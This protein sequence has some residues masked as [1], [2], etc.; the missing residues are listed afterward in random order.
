MTGPVS[1]STSAR[2][3]GPKWFTLFTVACLVLWT[4]QLAPLQLLLPLQLDT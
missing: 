4:V 2:R 3:V 1:T